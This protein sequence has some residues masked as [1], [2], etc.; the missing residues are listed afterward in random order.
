MGD[1]ELIEAALD[2]GNYR[3]A[4]QLLERFS[5]E[6]KHSHS[7]QIMLLMA[8]HAHLTHE[9][10]KSIT[11]LEAIPQQQKTIHV[12]LLLGDA[13]FA[14]YKQ[15]P[16]GH[17][18]RMDADYAL[19][20]YHQCLTQYPDYEDIAWVYYKIGLVLT[21][22]NEQESACS[23]FRQSL[24]MPSS[25]TLSVKSFA[26][27]KLA[28]Y[29]FYIA[30]DFKQA[31]QLLE[32]AIAV[33]APNADRTWFIHAL[34][35]KAKIFQVQHRSQ[36]VFHTLETAIKQAKIHFQ[37]DAG[38]LA[39]IYFSAGEIL[40]QAD[41]YEAQSAQYMQLYLQ[42]RTKPESIDVSWSRANEII[43][44]ALFFDGKHEQ[45]LKAY[46]ATLQYNPYHPWQM[47]I[48]YQ[49]ARCHYQEGD[50]TQTVKTLLQ[51]L[52]VAQRDNVTITDFR[53]YDM[54]GSAYFALG[55]FKAAAQSYREALKLTPPDPNLVDKIK[56][57]WHYSQQL[58]Q[59]KDNPK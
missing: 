14:R 47:T 40:V 52:D 24:N 4:G 35:F 54:L 31:H 44:N 36:E 19:Q 8:R 7:P 53:V 38:H 57:Y 56:L 41:G 5:V 9:H 48:H 37:H 29:E 20:N 1:L 23:Y 59:Q 10:T 11:L 6:A 16:I 13:Y 18:Q 43:A 2:K 26:Y 55:D 17:S 30:R 3:R 25:S 32:L 22:L 50:Y 49:I 12:F 39:D 34:L 21:A 51:L 28:Q 27:E 58:D 15:A 46:L 45:A 33:Y 42:L